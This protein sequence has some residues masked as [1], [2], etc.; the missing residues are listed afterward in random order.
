MAGKG[1]RS[2]IVL[3]WFNVSYKSV[4]LIVCAGIAVIAGGVTYWV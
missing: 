4:F 1:G 2:Q 3:D